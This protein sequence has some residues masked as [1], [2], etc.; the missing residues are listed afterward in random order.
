[1]IESAF[2]RK[3]RNP[4]YPIDTSSSKRSDEPMPMDIGIF[5]RKRLMKL[6]K[7]CISKNE[8]VF[9]VAKKDTWLIT[10]QKNKGANV[11]E[12]RC[13]SSLLKKYEY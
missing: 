10:A 1:M 12:G 9:A 7:I 3:N 8:D 13:Y 11:Y 4:I 6:K 5:T 2:G